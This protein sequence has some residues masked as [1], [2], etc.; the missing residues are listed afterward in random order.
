MK[1]LLLPA[2]FFFSFCKA[3]AQFQVKSVGLYVGP[4]LCLPIIKARND[5]P[6]QLPNGYATTNGQLADSL[7]KTDGLRI[8]YHG[9]VNMLLKFSDQFY[10]EVGI[11]YRNSGFRRHLYD[12]QKEDSMMYIG[13]IEDLSQSVPKNITYHFRY[14][15]LEVPVLF[16]YSLQNVEHRFDDVNYYLTFGISTSWLLQTNY[17]ARLFGFSVNEKN[18]FKGTDNQYKFATTGMNALLGAR[19]VSVMDEKWKFFFT[20]LIAYPLL[21]GTSNTDGINWKTSLVQLNFGF[22]YMF[23]DKSND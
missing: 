13:E 20:P 21:S 12:L 7:S 14:S 22:N 6:T 23:A 11:G 19:V 2:V 8:G 18:F 5:N 17:N 1:Y 4:D 3:N 16:H 15:Y 10:M 9:G